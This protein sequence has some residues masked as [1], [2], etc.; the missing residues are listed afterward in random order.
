MLEVLAG[1]TRSAAWR[2]GPRSCWGRPMPAGGSSGR[3]SRSTGRS[4]R[5]ITTG[6]SMRSGGG[7]AL[8]G[9]TSSSVRRA[10]RPRRGGRLRARAE[11]HGR[12][13]AQREREVA[14]RIHRGMS[15]REIAE[16]LVLGAHRRHSRAA[17]PRQ[18]RLLVARSDRGLVRGDGRVRVADYVVLRIPPP[19]AGRHAGERHRRRPSRCATSGIASSEPVRIP[20]GRHGIR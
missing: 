1:S 10:P 4:S 19:G 6:A 7:S 5:R 11:D 15:N 3:R 13:R 9:T 12:G 18:A 20:S 8:G 2:I 17:H 14:M 16:E